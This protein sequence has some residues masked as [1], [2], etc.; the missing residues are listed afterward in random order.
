MK[1]IDTHQHLIDPGQFPH[2]WCK[3]LPA[4]ADKPFRLEEYRAAAKGTGIAQTLFMESGVDEPH[5]GAETD[6]FLKLATRPDSG[7]AGVVAACRP[8][9]EDFPARLESS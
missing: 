9:H 2:S 4:L 7:I 5:A 1:I 6:F 3:D 8:E